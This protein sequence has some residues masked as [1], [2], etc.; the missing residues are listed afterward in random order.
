M[1]AVTSK[2]IQ[3]VFRV[4]CSQCGDNTIS[5]GPESH[6]LNALYDDNWLVM[7]GKVMCPACVVEYIDNQRRPNEP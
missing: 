4:K 1:Q 2:Y 3:K 5:T 6:F 7:D